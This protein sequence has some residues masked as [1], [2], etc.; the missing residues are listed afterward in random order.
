[1]EGEFYAHFLLVITTVVGGRAR[2]RGVSTRAP[3]A[4]PVDGWML[5]I[6]DLSDKAPGSTSAVGVDFVSPSSS[7]PRKSVG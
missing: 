6:L 3:T 4:A 5:R 7:R 2:Q 1:M